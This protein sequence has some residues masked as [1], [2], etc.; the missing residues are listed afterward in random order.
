LGL[1]KDN[2]GVCQNLTIKISYNEIGE[3]SRISIENLYASGKIINFDL[4]LLEYQ[5]SLRKAQLKEDSSY[6][7]FSSIH[8]LIGNLL[9]TAKMDNFHIAGK[10][11]LKLGS[12]NTPLNADIEADI[13]VQES[14]TY[15]RIQI[16]KFPLIPKVNT[17]L[18]GAGSRN[19]YAYYAPG[20]TGDDEHPSHMYLRTVDDPLIGRTKTN[21]SCYAGS[22][23]SDINHILDFILSKM[24]GL[25]E[26][27]VGN[28]LNGDSSSNEP[29]EFEN[30]F[31][32][33][34][35]G[36]VFNGSEEG[37]HSWDLSIRL[38]KLLGTSLLGDLSAN[39]GANGNG[40]FSSLN[41]KLPILSILTVN[42]PVS[43]DGT[44]ISSSNRNDYNS[45]ISSYSGS[46]VA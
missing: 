23:F 40:T 27:T 1:D 5:D 42:L 12:L 4:N 24:L 41:V 3:I 26:D 9:N 35:E 30:I 19:I 10:L 29:K 36:F 14:K 39:I 13:R 6:M 31:T 28:L 33:P 2:N 7:D 18:L 45:F 46:V 22:Y 37:E 16:L 25:N 11:N 20:I 34:S 32:S 38:G 21:D 17:G 43:L 44:E 15:A 8:T